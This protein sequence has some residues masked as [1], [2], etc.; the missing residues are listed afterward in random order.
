MLR[1]LVDALGEA[2]TRRVSSV[3]NAEKWIAAHPG[4]VVDM[5]EGDRIFLSVGAWEDFS[6][7][8]RDLRLLIAIDTVLGFAASVRAA[9]ERFGVRPEQSEQKS[10]ELSQLLASE[11]L[12]HTLSYTRSDG[13]QQRLTLKDVVERARG[14]EVAYNPNDCSELRWAAPPGSSELESCQRHAPP[15]QRA[16][17]DSYRAWFSTRNRPPQ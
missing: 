3:D 16:R 10:A 12:R 4:E 15:E 2:A 5:P 13:S 7:P 8:S 6:T 11:L 9:P 1:S 17:M 14:F